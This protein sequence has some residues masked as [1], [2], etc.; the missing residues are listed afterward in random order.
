MKRAELEALIKSTVDQE[1][2]E[3]INKLKAKLKETEQMLDQ[4][5]DIAENRGQS[6]VLYM[7]FVTKNNLMDEFKKFLEEHNKKELPQ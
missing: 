7:Q 1:T 5:I 6:T 4:V 3:Q 2:K